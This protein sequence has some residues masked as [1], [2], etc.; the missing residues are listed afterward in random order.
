MKIH[1]R[2][3]Y[4]TILIFYGVNTGYCEETN[5]SSC[6]GKITLEVFR[7]YAFNNSAV[8]TEI[9]YQFAKELANA[10]DTE[11]LANPELD[12]EQ[13]FTT[14]KINGDNDPQTSI[15]L[16]QPLNL[17]NFG[18]RQRLATLIKKTGDL[19]KK[20]KLLELNQQ[21]S[22][23]YYNLYYLQQTRKVLSE[24]E[25]R[26]VAKVELIK[27]GV[28][29]GLFTLGEEKIFEGEKYRLQAEIKGIEVA[30][31][32]LH[33]EMSNSLGIDCKFET[34]DDISLQD[35]PTIDRVILYSKKSS[36]SKLSRINLLSD[37]IAE[38][39]KL[40][41]LEKYPKFTPKLLYQHTNDS[42]DFFGVG[43]TLPL[44]IWNRNQSG[45][46]NSVAESKSIK[47]KKNYL[48]NNGFENQIKN[49]YYIVK[50][51]DEQSKIIS[52]KVIPA[53]KLALDSQEKL[54]RDGKGD[55][56]KVWQALTTYNEAQVKGLNLKIATLISRL[57]LNQLVGEEL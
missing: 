2:L 57:Q 24:A 55:I 46:M 42:G 28:I 3:V 45:R 10:I 27:N 54:Y 29:K 31:S 48:K 35:L 14:M 9:D 50:T 47:S 38:K 15:A 19:E 12:F 32:Q 7:A 56:L 37:F 21:I 52:Q 23:Y 30:I 5:K 26:S 39:N 44:P 41:E 25:K 43:I 36:L 33:Y 40:S 4:I 49:L 11:V 20:I 17:G 8:I 22:S 53:F 13:T 16:G 18:T 1:T 6:K 51:T 34:V